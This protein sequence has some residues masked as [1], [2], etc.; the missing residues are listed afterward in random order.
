MVPF[1]EANHFYLNFRFSFKKTQLK[2]LSK[3]SGHRNWLEVK[4]SQGDNMKGKKFLLPSV[5]FGQVH[6]AQNQILM[7]MLLIFFL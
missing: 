2:K 3:K 7:E 6:I 1:K 4:A 5:P